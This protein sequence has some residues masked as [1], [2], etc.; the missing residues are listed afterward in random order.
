MPIE[1]QRNDSAMN[2][3]NIVLP[4]YFVLRKTVL[5]DYRSVVQQLNNLELM[6]IAASSN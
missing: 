1:R 4:G 2:R 6:V 5:R 3:D